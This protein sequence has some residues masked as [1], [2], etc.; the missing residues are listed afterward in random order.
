M[1]KAAEN[2]T[3]DRE[4]NVLQ[5]TTTPIGGRECR[6]GCGSTP[7]G[8]V[9]IGTPAPT[10]KFSVAG[11]IE[12]T[13][14]GISSRTARRRRRRPDR[15]GNN[16]AFG[17]ECLGSLTTGGTNTAIG[18]E[19]LSANT[20]GGVGTPLPATRR[21]SIVNTTGCQHRQRPRALSANTTGSPNTASGMSALTPNTNGS[22]NTASGGG[23]LQEHD[24]RHNTASG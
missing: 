6:S 18:N 19:A 14:G 9:G 7:A 2:W 13:S 21:Y 24:R 1:Y 8:N 15:A 12:S 3:D 4:R 22:F 11:T 20:K 16:A 10:Q 23:A 5:F 17:L